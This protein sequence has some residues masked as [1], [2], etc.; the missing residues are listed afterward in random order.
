MLSLSPP[1][2]RVPRTKKAELK[3]TYGVD[4]LVLAFDFAQ[5]SRDAEAAFYGHQLP[6]LVAASPVHGDVGLLVNNVGVGDAAPYAVDEMKVRRPGHAR[7]QT[8]N[9][10]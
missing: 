3:A 9:A 10:Q 8:R 4:V 2:P 1:L 5:C 7:A 6:A